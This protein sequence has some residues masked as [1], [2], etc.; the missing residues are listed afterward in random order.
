[1][2][3]PGRFRRVGREAVCEPERRGQENGKG[4]ERTTEG[5][6]GKQKEYEEAHRMNQVYLEGS[7][8][9]APRMLD[10]EGAAPRLIFSLMTTHRS[11]AGVK[12]EYYPIRAWNQ[13]A[14]LGAQRLT[15]GARVVVEGYLTQQVGPEGVQVQVT[16]RRFHLL[17]AWEEA[18]EPQ[19][20]S[21]EPDEDRAS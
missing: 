9:N 13:L 5:R 11:K 21:E 15:P 4:G 7:V 6:T 10:Q 17:K 1:M 8:A 2:A 20:A 16:A 19:F 3:Q 12:K 14:R 18:P